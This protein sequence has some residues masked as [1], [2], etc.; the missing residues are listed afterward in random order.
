M[1]IKL[2]H[3][4]IKLIKKALSKIFFLLFRID[5][6]LGSEEKGCQVQEAQTDR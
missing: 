1:T 3:R 6:I 2:F 5:K 4:L